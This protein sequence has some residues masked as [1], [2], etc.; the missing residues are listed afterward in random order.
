MGFILNVKNLKWQN[1]KKTSWILIC[2]C[3][4]KAILI[5]N[6]YKFLMQREKLCDLLGKVNWISYFPC[7]SYM[8]TNYY[9]STYLSAIVVKVPISVHTP[10][11]ATL[12][13]W[14]QILLPCCPFAKKKA[15]PGPLVVW[16]IGRQGTQLVSRS[17][18]E[19]INT[20]SRV[21]DGRQYVTGLWR[22]DGDRRQHQDPTPSLRRHEESVGV[23]QPRQPRTHPAWTRTLQIHLSSRE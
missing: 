5:F 21:R 2:W 23:P 16:I 8:L 7:S 12:C 22:R 6:Y 14:K 1:W 18:D 13:P 9:E 15:S 4:P 20:I 19:C 3:H 17:F 10:R 11:L